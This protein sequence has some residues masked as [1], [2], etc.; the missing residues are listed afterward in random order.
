MQLHTLSW[1]HVACRTLTIVGLCSAAT[2]FAAPASC[3]P[4]AQAPSRELMQKA[5]Q[6]A[7]DRGLL[8]RISRDGRDSYLYGTIHAGRPEW[9]ALGPR[10]EVSLSRTGVLALEINVTDPA[11]LAALREAMQGPSRALPAELLQSLRSAWAAECLPAAD[12]EQGAAEVLVTQLAV[13]QAQRQ[14]LFPL[15]GAESVLLMRSL[16]T[17]RPVV[18]LESVQTQLSALMARSD[19]E[20]ATMVREMLAELQRPRA[21]RSMERLTRAWEAGDLKDLEAYADW[22]DCLHTPTERE[23]YARLVDG[24]NPGMAEAIGRL[25][26]NVS[27]F[28]AVGALHMVGPKGLPALLE[29][30][31]FKVQRVF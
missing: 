3:P 6:Q 27:V 22:C 29:A 24:R 25:H 26:A 1:R 15:Y 23:T 13:A 5:Q 28:A 12:L 4:Q 18:G 19:D 7:T 10:T 30:R 14:G 17:E 16:R 21:A 9:F 2:S 11:V 20:A 31:G 8:W